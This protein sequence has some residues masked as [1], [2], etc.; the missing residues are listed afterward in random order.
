[1]RAQDHLH[2]ELVSQGLFHL[3]VLNHVPLAQEEL[4]H[5]SQ[6]QHLRLFVWLVLQV[7]IQR[8]EDRY[9]LSVCLGNFRLQLLLSARIVRPARL[10]F[11]ELPLVLQILLLLIA[12]IQK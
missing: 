12:S 8:K 10:H 5:H 2:A 3:Q 6:E 7:I 1:M 9:V 11:Q 4:L